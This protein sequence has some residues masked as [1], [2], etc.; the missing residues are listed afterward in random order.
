MRA[1]RGPC[2]ALRSDLGYFPERQA[3]ATGLPDEPEQAEHLRRID[4]I[5]GRGTAGTGNDAARLIQPERLP[6]DAAPFRHV[7]NEQAVHATRI[8]LAA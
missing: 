8:D 6:G 1:R 7:A 2:A 3:K 4:P 5:A